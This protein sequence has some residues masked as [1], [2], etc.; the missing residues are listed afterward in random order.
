MT[1]MYCY[2]DLCGKEMLLSTDAMYKYKLRKAILGGWRYIEAH[3]ECVNRLCDTVEERREKAAMTNADKIRQIS[4]EEM[5][6]WITEYVLNMQ[7][8][9]SLEIAKKAWLDWLKQEVENE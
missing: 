8:N 3:P 9:G 4:D 2:C 5:A 6:E 1:K 7:N